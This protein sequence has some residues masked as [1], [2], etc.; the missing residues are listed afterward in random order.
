MVLLAISEV[1]ARKYNRVQR[2]L[3]ESSCHDVISI[4]TQYVDTC[5]QYND[6]SFGVEFATPIGDN[7]FITL[8]DDPNIVITMLNQC[9][10]AMFLVDCEGN[11]YFLE[12][13]E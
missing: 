3:E 12:F 7:Y 10:D 8:V 11:H 5:Y 1:N 6:G 9:V 2:W 13:I 4:S